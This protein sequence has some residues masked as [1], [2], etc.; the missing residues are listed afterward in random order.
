MRGESTNDE[1]GQEN[2]ESGDEESRVS[3]TTERTNV[4]RKPAPIST[5]STSV[6]TGGSGIIGSNI[7]SLRHTGGQ[8]DTLIL[9]VVLIPTFLGLVI[10]VSLFLCYV[11]KVKVK[12]ILK[13]AV[14]PIKK[15]RKK[16]AEI[17]FRTLK[18][19]EDR[20]Q[21]Y[22]DPSTYSTVTSGKLAEINF[23]TQKEME[24][25]NQTYTDPSTYSTVENKVIVSSLPVN[26]QNQQ[27][28]LPQ[29]ENYSALDRENDGKKNTQIDDTDYDSLNH[30]NRTTI[31]STSDNN[32]SSLNSAFN[33]T[34]NISP[35]P[36][37][38]YN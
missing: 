35:N 30:S 7:T 26:S 15:R 16:E 18:E 36:Y 37:G 12:E 13:Q 21:T 34:E 22:T 23:R 31:S 19:M 11:Y 8:D 2:D 24:D 27:E 1:S 28:T 29:D 20:N 25:R 38:I 5:V 3:I 14:K 4:T 10:I 6:T 32:Y 17:N 9:H 33:S